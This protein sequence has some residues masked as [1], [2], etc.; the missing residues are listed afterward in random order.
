[1]DKRTIAKAIDVYSTIV[2][3]GSDWLQ[4]LTKEITEDERKQFEYLLARL[5]ENVSAYIMT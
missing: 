3:K 2:E 1:M 4:I 5:A